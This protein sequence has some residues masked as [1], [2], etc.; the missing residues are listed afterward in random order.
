MKSFIR[1]FKLATV[2]GIIVSTSIFLVTSVA[3]W[4]LYEDNKKAMLKNLKSQGESILNFAD[5]LFESRNEKF[6]SGESPEIPQV[7]QN[8]IF[9]RFTNISGGK[10]F[11]KQASKHPM[12]ERNK[13]LPYEERLIEYFNQNLDKKQTETFAKEKNKELYVVARPI[14]AE[15]RCKSCHPTWETG[16]VIATENAKIDTSDFKEALDSNITVMVINWFL[17]IILAVIA[18][19]LYFYFEI[20]KRVKKILDITFRIENGNFI[21]DD[22]LKDENLQQ[23]KSNNEIDRII[24]H[25]NR[26]AQNLKPVIT[27]VVNQSKRMT[28][29]ASYATIKVE[30]NYHHIK[31]QKDIVDDSI[32]SIKNVN[33]IS[34]VLTNQLDIIKEESSNSIDSVNE[35]KNVLQD[36][37]KQVDFASESMN[38]TI[39]SIES[40]SSL[41]QEVANA[42]ET[43][44]DISDQTNLLA[45]NA[46]I[47]AA[48]AGEHGRGFA[49]VAD[50]VRKLA[51]KSAQSANLIKSVIQNIIQS[52]HDVTDDASKTKE[53]FV[54]LEQ[55]TI[56]LENKF[57]DIEKTLNGTINSISDFHKQFDEQ[58]KELDDVNN[59]LNDV[60][61]QSIL[62]LNEITKLNDIMDGIMNESAELKTLSDNFEV[63]LNKRQS[64]RTIIS[65][66]ITCNIKTSQGKYGVYI[67]DKSEHGVSFYFCR[68]NIPEGKTVKIGMYIGVECS[69]KDVSGNYK[70]V[71]ISEKK[72]ER[73]FCGAKRV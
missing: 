34:E 59:S 73:F 15:E 4:K 47:E 68:D 63:I 33:H 14:K 72:D 55:T 21:L 19:Q 8:D 37:V 17:N 44:S 60:S 65:P 9:K 26:V 38:Q 1:K 49:V 54:K 71:Y 30:N 58:S 56:E 24:R 45:L 40:L 31:K 51:E 48:R 43:I 20:S 53:T 70:I 57:D 28:F 42:V 11:F 6:F 12:L 66:P 2:A 62:T 67:F 25:L 23:G 22:L 61:K 69:D 32:T 39:S 13:A 46:A 50:E 3:Y 16:K 10:V 64:I 36:N 5:V 35:G 18:I 29:D 41:S 27:S 7:I 52:I